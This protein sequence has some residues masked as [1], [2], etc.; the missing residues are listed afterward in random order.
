MYLNHIGHELGS[1]K[2]RAIKK[3]GKAKTSGDQEMFNIFDK[4]G[5]ETTAVYSMEDYEVELLDMADAQVMQVGKDMIDY[6]TGQMSKAWLAQFIDLGTT[7]SGNRAL[8]ESQIQF[9]TNGL[10]SIAHTLI[11]VP[12]NTL[13]ADI[14]T[15]NFNRGIFPSLKVN[16]IADETAALLF[17]VF[18]EMSKKGNIPDSIKAELLG[19]TSEKLAFDL[20]TEAIKEELEQEKA[21]KEQAA[22]E[23]QNNIQANQAQRASDENKAK[24]LDNSDL[25]LQDADIRATTRGIVEDEVSEQVERGPTR[26]FPDQENVKFG[27]IARKQRDLRET[28]ERV[29]TDKFTSQG[30]QT[31]DEFLVASRKG[32]KSIGKVKIELQETETKYSEELLQV[33]LEALEFGKIMSANELK[34]AVPN[35]T[36]AQRQLVI[37]EVE[38]IIEKQQSDLKFRLSNVAANSIERDIPENETRLLLEQELAAFLAVALPPTLRLVVPTNFNRGRQ[39]TFEKYTDDI[40]GRRYAL[41][42]AKQHTDYC[43]ALVGRVFQEN[44]PNWATVDPPNH[45]G[46]NG[47]WTAVTNEEAA[48]G[49]VVDGKPDRLPVFSSISTFRDVD[50]IADLSEIEKEL[51]AEDKLK[52]LISNI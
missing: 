37:D 25:N 50:D 35:T 6:H 29:L 12:W 7:E 9:F 46:C 31:I 47:Y 15:I 45:I 24:M 26:I 20:E 52:E 34:K 30:E 41:F 42:D 28:A 32:V 39:I 19:K 40:F 48:A 33:A 36:R 11:E 17:E 22:Q 3:K 2:F 49:I 5:V 10:Q 8:G 51:E 23:I 18:T 4:A 43:L 14:V 1:V 13:I 38:R 27:D 16:P 44:D 21:D